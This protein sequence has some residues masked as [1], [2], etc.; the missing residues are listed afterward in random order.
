[1]FNRE[2]FIKDSNETLIAANQFLTLLV[3]LR[4]KYSDYED[5][6]DELEEI[7]DAE[8]T[9]IDDAFDTVFATLMGEDFDKE[10][11]ED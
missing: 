4:N 5:A 7:G 10:D 1:M 6:I 8:L 2:E 3:A 11:E 9:A